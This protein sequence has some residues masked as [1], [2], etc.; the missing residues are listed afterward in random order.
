MLGGVLIHISP[1]L[2]EL[3]GVTLLVLWYFTGLPTA[4]ETAS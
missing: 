1:A 4:P 2:P 3:L